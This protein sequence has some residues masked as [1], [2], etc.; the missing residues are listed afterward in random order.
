MSIYTGLPMVLGWDWHQSQQ[1]WAYRHQVEDRKRDVA[2]MYSTEDQGQTLDLL[3]KYQV[4]YVYVGQLERAFYPGPGLQKFE[5]L[6]AREAL[7]PVYRNQEVTIYETA[8]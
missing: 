8:S 7:K 2:A 5:A 3:K 4:R 1:R 6:A